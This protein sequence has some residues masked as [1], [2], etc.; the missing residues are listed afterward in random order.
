MTTSPRKPPKSDCWTCDATGTIR[1][2]DERC[3]CTVPL[4]PTPVYDDGN[5]D[6]EGSW[7]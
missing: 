1:G 6:D 2:T 7:S 3:P 4:K 5:D